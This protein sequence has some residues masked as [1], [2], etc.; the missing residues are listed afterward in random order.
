MP[1]AFS[2]FTSPRTAPKE[3]GL[4]L[5]SAL[6]FMGVTSGL[7]VAAFAFLL[8]AMTHTGPDADL[9]PT[10]PGV[11]L[12]KKI[13][14]LGVV[15]CSGNLA[16]IAGAWSW[17]RWGVY[18]IVALQIFGTLVGLK[19]GATLSLGSWLPTLV[20]CALALTRWSDFE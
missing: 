18:G 9:N 8:N 13:M 19:A 14:L 20:L 3:R 4:L 12:L 11:A 15:V 5:S 10:D 1:P 17:K 7:G 16:C 2:A 6:M